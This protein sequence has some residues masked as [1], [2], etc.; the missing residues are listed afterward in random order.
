MMIV[1]LVMILVMI[2][3]KFFWCFI[4]IKVFIESVILLD[5]VIV[6]LGCFDLVLIFLEFEIWKKCV[7]K[8]KVWDYF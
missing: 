4:R 7:E 8:D 3:W 6:V 5:L 2:Y 1:Y